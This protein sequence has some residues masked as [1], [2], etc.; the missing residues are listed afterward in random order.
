MDAEKHVSIS[1]SFL[2]QQ[3]T[4]RKH[5]ETFSLSFLY[6]S[7]GLINGN[8]SRTVGHDLQRYFGAYKAIRVTCQLISLQTVATL[9]KFCKGINHIA[10]PLMCLHTHTHTLMYIMY[11]MVQKSLDSRGNMLKIL[12]VT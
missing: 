8:P 4:F 11:R 12:S 7:R 2:I 5:T 9:M 1:L 3:G 10:F 6:G